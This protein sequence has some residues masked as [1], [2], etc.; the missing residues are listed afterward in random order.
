MKP[1]WLA[2]P[3]CGERLSTACDGCGQPLQPPWKFCPTCG[4]AAAR[5]GS[6]KGKKSKPNAKL[7]SDEVV[8]N[9]LKTDD[10][11]P[12]MEDDEAI[13]AMTDKLASE[14]TEEQFETL[15]EAFAYLNEVFGAEDEHLEEAESIARD[16]SE[17]QFAILKE[18]LDWAS[19]DTDG[20]Q[21]DYK[22]ALKFA[23]KKARLTP[24]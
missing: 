23:K 22:S 4:K 12:A 16:L 19:N 15:K 11:G 9:W 21:M 18:K 8:I 3:N 10:D 20:P 2:C 1:D 13:L 17:A 24:P 6:V 14:L 5:S 7:V